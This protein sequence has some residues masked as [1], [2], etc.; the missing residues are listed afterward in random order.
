MHR[1]HSTTLHGRRHI[2]LL[3]LHASDMGQQTLRGVVHLL[4]PS[5]NQKPWGQRNCRDSFSFHSINH[6]PNVDR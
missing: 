1:C 6:V 3:L 5:G 4:P 2:V